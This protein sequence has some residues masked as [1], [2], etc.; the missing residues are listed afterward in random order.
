MGLP[1]EPVRNAETVVTGTWFS[2]S[3][4]PYPCDHTSRRFTPIAS[5]KPGTWC[6]A[7]YAATVESTR[8]ITA[9]ERV[10]ERWPN[11]TARG[12]T[13]STAVT[14]SGEGRRMAGR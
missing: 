2:R 5:D 8:R 6:A 12:T 11:A 9:S 3:A 4:E 14:E 13:R 1:I 10:G 7:M